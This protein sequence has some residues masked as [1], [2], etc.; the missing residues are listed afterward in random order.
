MARS[1]FGTSNVTHVDIDLD[2][3][4]LATY[5]DRVPVIK[6]DGGDVIDEGIVEE[7]IL[8]ASLAT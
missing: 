7:R 6:T 5:T 1:V 3:G 4:L 2:L 8:L